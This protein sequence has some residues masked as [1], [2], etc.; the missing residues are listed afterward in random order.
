MTTLIM[1]IWLSADN[2]EDVWMN[3]ELKQSVDRCLFQTGK[4]AEINL[5][6]QTAA[7]QYYYG[8]CRQTC[9]VHVLKPNLFCVFLR[10]IDNLMCCVHWLHPL[11]LLLK[12]STATDWP[13]FTAVEKQGGRNQSR[14]KLSDWSECLWLWTLCP[15]NASVFSPSFPK[16]FSPE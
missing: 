15:T 9:A 3:V 4:W 5:S 6:E 2:S 1:N 13:Q 7:C 16:F 8:L 14:V 11:W 10:S 12:L